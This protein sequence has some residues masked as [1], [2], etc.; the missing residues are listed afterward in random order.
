[1]IANAGKGAHVGSVDRHAHPDQPDPGDRPDATR[2][3]PTSSREREAQLAERL[4]PPTLTRASAYES[5]YA[6]ALAQDAP[7]RE[8][9]AREEAAIKRESLSPAG[10]SRAPQDPPK[11]RTDKPERDL[12]TTRTFWTEVPRFLS[13]WQDHV[14]RWPWIRRLENRTINPEQRAETTDSVRELF[15]AEPSISDNVKTTEAYND[16]DGWLEGFEFRLKGEGRIIEKVSEV[17]E[18]SSPDATACEIVQQ[19]PD[20][21]RYTFC[22]SASDYTAGC[23]DIRDRLESC[24]YEMYNLKN[25]WADPEYKGINTRWVTPEGHRFEVQFH[26]RESFHAKHHVTHEAYERLRNPLTS[27]A[28]RSELSAFQREV[29]SWIPAPNDVAEISDHKKKG[30]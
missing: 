25:S 3:Q 17:L 24:G 16:R 11:P 29:S 30:F 2:E 14:E 26:T 20:A 28:E 13:L 21:I 1:V 4:G 19:I 23:R 7:F 15:Q 8:R 12:E 27:S 18:T 9:L 10:E 6:R 5:L 22:L